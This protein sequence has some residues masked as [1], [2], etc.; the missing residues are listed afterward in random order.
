L[1]YKLYRERIL[2]WHRCWC[3]RRRCMS[4]CPPPRSLSLLALYLL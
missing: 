3:G 1:F 2:T 4:S